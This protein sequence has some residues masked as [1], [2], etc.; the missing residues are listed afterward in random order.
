VKGDTSNQCSVVLVLVLVLVVPCKKNSVPTRVDL[1]HVTGECTC[2]IACSSD[3]Q[4]AKFHR[5][6]VT[7][8]KGTAVTT[9]LV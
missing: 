3:R 1:F 6:V 5:L 2:T 4:N 7:D 8:D 9:G